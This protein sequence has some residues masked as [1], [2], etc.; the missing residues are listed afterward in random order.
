MAWTEVGLNFNEFVRV[1]QE[2]GSTKRLPQ[3]CVEITGSQYPTRMQWPLVRNPANRV[4]WSQSQIELRPT[5]SQSVG[6]FWCQAPIWGPWRD[7]YYCQTDADLLISGPIILGFESCRTH[8]DIQLSHIWD[9]P[10]L[11]VY[12]PG[13]WIIIQTNRL[14]LFKKTIS[15]FYENH[16][17][18]TN[19]VRSSQETHYF[20]AT[21]PN[22]LMLFKKTISVSYENHT[23]TQIQFVAHRKH[24]TSLLQ[25]PTG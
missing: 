11:E 4:I 19:T 24:I 17:E 25:S 6:R 1:P 3:T 20:S 12:I 8:D 10:N 13:R 23:N 9:S 16:T 18:H 14:M 5:F 2:F 15:V 21:E 7:F 22:R